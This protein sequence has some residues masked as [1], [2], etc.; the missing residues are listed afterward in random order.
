MKAH[1]LALA[2][3]IVATALVGTAL[4]DDGE[5]PTSRDPAFEQ[6]IADRLGQISPN[7]VPVFEHAT[8]AMDADDLPAAREGYLEVLSLAPEFPDAL[9]RLSHV[10]RSAGDVS[11]AVQYAYRAFTVDPSPHNRLALAFAL[12]G[13]DNAANHRSALEDARA[14]VEALPDDPYALTVLAF[15]GAANEDTDAMRGA[16]DRLLAVA[17]EN[18]LGHFFAAML[19]SIDGEWEE[20]ERELLES[21]RLGMPAEDVRDAL[22]I[23]RT[24]AR[25]GRLISSGLYAL[26]VWLATPFLL[27]AAGVVFSNATLAAA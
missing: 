14:G 26:G 24:E 25:R 8:R 16:T 5:E 1:P 2:L 23:A 3:L 20:A 4:A 12:L 6:E 15:A 27:L 10:E 9:R 7:A 18:P 17:P 21:E 19:A 11:A 13:T 22:A